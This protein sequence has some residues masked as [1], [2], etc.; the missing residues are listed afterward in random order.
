MAA[1]FDHFQNATLNAEDN[2]VLLIDSYAPVI[3]QII[4][5]RFWTVGA[6]VVTSVYIR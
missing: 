5:R 2:M 6:A 1:A 3:L 4:F